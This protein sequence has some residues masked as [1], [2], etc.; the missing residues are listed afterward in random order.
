MNILNYY[1]YKILYP[2]FLFNIKKVLKEKNMIIRLKFNDDTLEFYVIFEESIVRIY[3]KTNEP[4]KIEKVIIDDIIKTDWFNN[5]KE[6]IY[7]FKINA[8]IISSQNVIDHISNSFKEAISY[9]KL[10]RKEYELIYSEL[11][12][13]KSFYLQNTPA[14]VIENENIKNKWID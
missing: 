11:L 4:I 3:K 6:F 10:T 14:L 2:K 9:Y 13:F 1:N 7:D 5:L 8:E 12:K